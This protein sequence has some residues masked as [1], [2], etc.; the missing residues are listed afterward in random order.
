MVV[1]FLWRARQ[2]D[3]PAHQWRSRVVIGPDPWYA[4]QYAIPLLGMMPGNT[5]TG[6]SLALDRLASS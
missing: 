4:P 6:V 2:Q 1:A 3:M 5:M